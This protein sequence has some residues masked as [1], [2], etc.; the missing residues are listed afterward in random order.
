MLDARSEMEWLVRNSNRNGVPDLNKYFKGSK[1]RGIVFGWGGALIIERFSDSDWA[2]DKVSRILTSGYTFMLNGGPDSRCSKRQPTVALS[3]TEAEYNV[4]TL[5]ANDATGL[6]L[7]LT[8]LRLLGPDDQHAGISVKDDMARREQS[9][10]PS[11]SIE[12]LPSTAEM[13]GE[14]QGSD[15]FAHSPIFHAWTKLIGIQHHYIRNKVV[16][17]RINLTYIA[18]TQMIADSLTKPLTLA[19]FHEFVRE[20]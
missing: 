18:T 2:G 9:K 10:Q 7:L 8:E 5:V 16:A 3:S 12:Q 14:N 13:K 17:G 6:R 15:A 19:K 11:L 4:P 1:D 20:L